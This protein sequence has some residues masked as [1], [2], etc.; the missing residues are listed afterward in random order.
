MTLSFYT[1]TE[2]IREP[3]LYDCN[4]WW[5]Y[6]GVQ[7]NTSNFG[8]C[9]IMLCDCIAWFRLPP[10]IL[11]VQN[12]APLWTQFCKFWIKLIEHIQRRS[13]ESD[14]T[15]TQIKTLHTLSRKSLD[16]AQTLE[17]QPHM[18]VLLKYYYWW[19]KGCY[20]I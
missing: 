6:W 2:I 7:I 14:Q 4:R 16:W 12:P 13:W 1:F 18:L 17:Y 20:L 5:Y 15:W 3:Y 10:L 8:D 9:N 11:Y 19:W